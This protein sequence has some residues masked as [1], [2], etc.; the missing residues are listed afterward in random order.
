MIK[1]TNKT[2]GQSRQAIW[3]LYLCGGDLLDGGFDNLIL[4]KFF[5]SD[6]RMPEQKALS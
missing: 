6:E 2:N 4:F 5:G 3:M 1:F